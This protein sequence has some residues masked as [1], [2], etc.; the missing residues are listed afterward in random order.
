MAVLNAF[1]YR[2]KPPI[3]NGYIHGLWRSKRGF[4]CK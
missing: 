1:L 2:T 4:C 3:K